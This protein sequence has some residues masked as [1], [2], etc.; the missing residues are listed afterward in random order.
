M[1]SYKS[2]KVSLQPG[3]LQVAIS[4]LTSGDFMAYEFGGSYN[5]PDPWAQNFLC[6]SRPAPNVVGFCDAKFDALAATG[7]SSQDATARV[8]AY[9]DAQ[10]I[11]YDQVPMMYYEPAINFYVFR[12]N[13]HD[14]RQFENGAI[15]YGDLWIQTR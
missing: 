14:I 7:R 6:N 10:K 13:V 5:D 15:F 9:R 1:Q 8:N 3:T 12:N 11:I 2:I 4:K